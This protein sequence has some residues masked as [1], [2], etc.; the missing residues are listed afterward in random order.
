MFKIIKDFFVTEKEWGYP[1]KDKATK[2]QQWYTLAICLA[3]IYAIS[4]WITTF[5]FGLLETVFEK[6]EDNVM[7][8]NETE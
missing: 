1:W 7:E 6:N 8:E 4:Y 3:G 2:F 5:I